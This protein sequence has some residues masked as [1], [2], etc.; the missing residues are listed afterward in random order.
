[1]TRYAFISVDFVSERWNTAAV[2]R[3]FLQSYQA[4]LLVKGLVLTSYSTGL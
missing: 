1:M 2:F 3:V 4:I